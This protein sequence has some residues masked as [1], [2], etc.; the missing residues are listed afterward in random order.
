MTYGCGYCAKW[1]LK[2]AYG[3]L[4]LAAGADKFFNLITNWSVFVSPVVLE[5]IPMNL[6]TL[7][8]AAGILEIVI[9]GLILSHLTRIGA[10]IGFVWLLLIALNFLTMGYPYDIAVHDIILAVGSLALACLSGNKNY[11][12]C[13][14]HK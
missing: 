14:C 8:S 6:L 5:Y 10:L 2:L 7:V 1:L 12:K 9:G 3:L 11:D 13:T 4:F